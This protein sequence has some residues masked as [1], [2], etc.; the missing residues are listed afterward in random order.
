MLIDRFGRTIDYIRLSVTDRCDYRCRYCMPAN[1]IKLI[2][3]KDILSYEEIAKIVTAF[4]KRGIKKSKNNRR[5][6]SC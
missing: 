1:G 6:A 5:R 4:A 2:N 3:R